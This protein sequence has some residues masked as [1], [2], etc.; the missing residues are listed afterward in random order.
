MALNYSTIKIRK[1]LYLLLPSI[2][3]LAANAGSLVIAANPVD[4]KQRTAFN[5]QID[6]FKRAHPDIQVTLKIQEH[7]NY[8]RYIRSN[9]EKSAPIADVIYWFGGASL[10]DFAAKGWIQDLSE[11]WQEQGWQDSFTPAAKD[12]ASFDAGQYGLPLYYYHWGIYYRISVFKKL[13]LKPPGTWKEMIRVSQKLKESGVTPFTM[14]NKNHWPAAGWFDYLNLRINGLNYHRRLLQGCIPFTDSGV[15][16]IFNTW[17]RMLQA[18]FVIPDSGELDW[19]AALPYLYHGKAA[20]IL[21]GNFFLNS[22]PEKILDDI[23]FFPFPEINP[24][25]PLYENAPTDVLLMASTAKNRAEAETF[26]RFMA[27]PDVQAASAAD[28]EMIPTHRGA[29]LT[30]NRHIG[31]GARLLASA[32]GLAQFFDRDTPPEFVEK[33]LPIFSRFVANPFALNIT[34]SQL[35]QARQEVWPET[36]THCSQ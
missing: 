15:E 22:V 10:R 13:G 32:Q 26:L 7:E 6:T 5:I 33:A 9:L 11:L 18:G 17:Q 30:D 36:S 8:K 20:M 3:S 31:E 23:G 28:L 27:R 19:R 2:F 21:M 1:L 12:A 24:D 25:I 16:E 14:G 4:G 34:I 29:T 35:E